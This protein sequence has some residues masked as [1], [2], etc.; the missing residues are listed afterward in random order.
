MKLHVNLRNA[1][2]TDWSDN[3]INPFDTSSEFYWTWRVLIQNDNKTSNVSQGFSIGCDLSS[4]YSFNND[5]HKYRELND[6][7]FLIDLPK[8]NDTDEIHCI[9]EL[10]CWESDRNSEM[11]KIAF[12][13]ESLSQLV[14][15]MSGQNKKRQEIEDEV[16]KWLNSDQN[17]IL[18]AI[19]TAGYVT[20]PTL[21]IATEVAGIIFKI[22]RNSGD[23]YVGKWSADL[24]I[25]KDGDKTRYRWCF[26]SG[27]ETW[28]FDEDKLFREAIFESDDR[29]N[30]IVG[31]ILLQLMK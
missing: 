21:T 26:D 14:K 9:V 7:K 13:N 17:S 4:G 5:G 18:Q 3:P 31:N 2:C 11:V 15:I 10:H 1:T 8:A 19:Q 6:P 16:V 12:A 30:R 24:F 23:E 28:L 25:G 20:A 27:S 29:F 22:I